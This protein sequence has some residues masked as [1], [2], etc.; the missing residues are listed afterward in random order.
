[1]PDIN[2]LA[3]HAKPSLGVSFAKP[4]GSLMIA[5]DKAGK[6]NNGSRSGSF[7]I[8]SFAIPL[9]TI[10]AMFLFELF[11]PVVMLIFGLFFMLRLKF[12][13]PPELSVAAELHGHLDLKAFPLLKA[14]LVA[15]ASIVIDDEFEGQDEMK[16]AL[17][18]Q[19][20]ADA[21]ADMEF[22]AGVAAA[23]AR[24]DTPLGTAGGPSVAAG[25]V[26]QAEVIHP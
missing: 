4:P 3:A 11:L 1:M 22:E 17:S 23:A 12:C 2:A 20:E 10:V 13:I 7:E 14:D 15:N 6:H 16:N 21:I 26:W 5:G 18:G 9:F 8:C 19:F 24:G 25:L